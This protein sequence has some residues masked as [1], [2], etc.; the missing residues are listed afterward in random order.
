[1]EG[2]TRLEKPPLGVVPRWHHEEMRVWA[3]CDAIIRYKAAGH[4]ILVEWLD[5]LAHLCGTH[6]WQKE[7]KS[8]CRERRESKAV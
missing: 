1:M 7:L 4:P 6:D 5:E 3:I 2:I 8:T